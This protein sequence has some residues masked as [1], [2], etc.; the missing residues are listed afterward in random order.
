VLVFDEIRKFA[1]RIVRRR[2]SAAAWRGRIPA[3]LRRL[4]PNA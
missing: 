1:E 3:A 2:L 4:K